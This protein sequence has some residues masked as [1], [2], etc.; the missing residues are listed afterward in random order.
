M[1]GVIGR[2]GKLD[3]SDALDCSKPLL[4]VGMNM[5]PLAVFD[6]AFKQNEWL[7]QRQSVISTN[8]AN[9]NTPGYKSKDIASFEATLMSTEMPMAATNASHMVPAGVSGAGMATRNV[10]PAEVLHSGND[11]K[12]DNEFLK[13][14][15]VMRS[16]TMNTQIVKAFNRM[17]LLSA[18][19]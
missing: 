15:E 18:K 13:A 10:N 2:I 8:I 5:Q 3:A 6:W 16:Y 4:T 17:L 11:V 9:A 1:S 19:I 12:L 7:S 14:G